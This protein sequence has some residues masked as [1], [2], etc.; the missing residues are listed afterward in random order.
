MNQFRPGS[1]HQ[2]G[3][4]PP[5]YLVV[6]GTQDAPGQTRC[7]HHGYGPAAL[8]ELRRIAQEMDL[9]QW[10]GPDRQ[11]ELT[12]LAIGTVHQNTATNHVHKTPGDT[13]PEAGAA[14]LPGNRG[15]AL[16]KGIKQSPQLFRLHANAG[17]HYPGHQQFLLTITADHQGDGTFVS[18]LQGIATQV[19]DDLSQ[20]GRVGTDLLRQRV[21]TDDAEIQ[22]LFTGPGGKEGADF[23]KKFRQIDRYDI[24]IQFVGVDLRMVE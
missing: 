24:H 15:A 10:P 5:V 14:V 18:E 4:K 16:G 21:L 22:T 23:I 19:D 2:Q 6:F 13:E 9:F 3:H 1:R 12:A 20:S 8:A 11:L 17:I 7:Y